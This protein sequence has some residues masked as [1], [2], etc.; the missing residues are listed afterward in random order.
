MMLSAVIVDDE[1]LA[2]DGLKAQCERIEDLE[3]VGTA[4]DGEAALGLLEA[5]RPDFLFLDIGMPGLTG[6]DIASRLQQMSDPPLVIFATAYGHFATEAFDLGVT[7]SILK[8]IEAD[9]LTRAIERVRT[10]I[11]RAGIHFTGTSC[12]VEEIWVPDRGAML[13]LAFNSISRIEAYGDYVRIYSATRAYLLRQTMSAIEKRLD[14]SCF[15]R[16]HR[17]AIV[18]KDCI[19]GLKHVGSGAWA[20]A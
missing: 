9:R 7:D 19:R 15:V 3:I 8:P 14:P 13:R 4:A 1:P 5:Q 20:E 10:A 18:R 2:I 12:R 16:V 17:S 6:I 11:A